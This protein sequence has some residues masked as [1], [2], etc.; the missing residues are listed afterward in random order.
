[1]STPLLFALAALLVLIAVPASR[2]LFNAMR[3][4]SERDAKRRLVPVRIKD[5]RDPYDR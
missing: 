2:D 3:A 4:Q 5:E 1:M